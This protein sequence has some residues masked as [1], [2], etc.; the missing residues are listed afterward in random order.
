VR[1]V[2][3]RMSCTQFCP[4]VVCF[5]PTCAS[6]FTEPAPAEIRTLSLHDALPISPATAAATLT[7][8]PERHASDDHVCPRRS[9]HPEHGR[10]VRSES[11]RLN[12]S[13]VK[14]SYAVFCL[15]KKRR[16]AGTSRQFAK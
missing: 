8:D 9:G 12:S 10:A 2:Y 14:S 6:L 3:L 11:T 5:A 1:R 4:I 13:H 16:I 7:H 15:K